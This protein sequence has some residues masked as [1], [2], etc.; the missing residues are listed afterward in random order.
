MSGS[1][2]PAVR[3]AQVADTLVDISRQTG[4][5]LEYKMT[6]DGFTVCINVT[7]Q[8]GENRFRPPHPY[9]NVGGW[10]VA[11][12][13]QPDWDQ[14]AHPPGWQRI[15]PPGDATMGGGWRMPSDHEEEEDENETFNDAARGVFENTAKM[16]PIVA[17]VSTPFKHE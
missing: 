15:N 16:S 7:K 4:T 9:I 3:V 5:P 6:I 12:A 17:M 2:S 1:P 11:V 10:G 14:P 8:F 13:G